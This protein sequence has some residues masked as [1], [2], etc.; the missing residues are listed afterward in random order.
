[1]GKGITFDGKGKD[2]GNPNNTSKIVDEMMESHDRYVAKAFLDLFDAI[3]TSRSRECD[4]YDEWC[5]A[6]LHRLTKEVLELKLKS[7]ATL[8]DIIIDELR[9]V[10]R[11]VERRK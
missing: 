4:T 11:E 9:A 8:Q 7:D 5:E 2:A 3:T 10:K 1:M 6:Y